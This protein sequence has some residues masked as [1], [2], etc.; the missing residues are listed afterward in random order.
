LGK[1][2][3][4]KP[5][6][7]LINDEVRIEPTNLCN[8]KCIMCPR[9]KLTRKQ[10]V[11]GVELFRQIVDEVVHYGANKISIEN[12]GETFLDPSI[13][14]KAAY[15]KGKGL[16]T[17][18]ISNASLIDDKVANNILDYFDVIR[19]SLYGVTK[20]VYESIHKKLNYDTVI[21][22]LDRLLTLRENKMSSTTK[23]EIYFLLMQEN[24]HQL[25]MFLDRYE[26]IVDGVSVWRPH[27]WSNG[28]LYRQ[29]AEKKISCGRP[30]NGPLQVQWD[31]KV[32]PCCFDY[33]S[34]IVLGNLNN[35]SVY[36]ILSSDKYN[37]LREAHR[38]GDFEKYPFCNSCDQLNKREDVLVYSNIPGAAVGATN[39]DR[40]NL[41]K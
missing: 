15:A 35:Q 26:K 11:M 33:D 6:F 29:A 22:N 12:F 25:K 19:I 2:I 39:T 28:R 10:S 32:V 41:A 16:K 20:D 40:H 4:Y 9:E 37:A 31:G 7:Q 30:F 21:K 13:F 34:K 24:E 38:K 18:T 14:E 23:I 3:L 17:L 36:E 8:A 5:G 1:N 27:N